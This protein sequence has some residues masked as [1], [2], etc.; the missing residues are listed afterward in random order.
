MVS[1]VSNRVTNASFR[2]VFPRSRQSRTTGDLHGERERKKAQREV[3]RRHRQTSQKLSVDS[4]I[5]HQEFSLVTEHKQRKIG[6]PLNFHCQPPPST[7]IVENF[8]PFE[9]ESSSLRQSEYFNNY[10]EHPFEWKAI[11][12][13]GNFRWHI[14]QTTRG[15]L[16]WMFL[17]PEESN[18]L[19][20]TIPLCERD[21]GFRFSKPQELEC[22]LHHW[23][24]TENLEILSG[25]R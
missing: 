10:Y 11:P 8:A 21:E 2:F 23:A 4:F 22:L 7:V 19:S 5:I 24:G 1:M 13:G 16:L 6:F 3:T 25:S 15:A 14:W 20:S 18:H 17:I 9:R 12:W